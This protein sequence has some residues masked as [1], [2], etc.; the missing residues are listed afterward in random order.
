MII[1]NLPETKYK[2]KDLQ[3]AI[4]TWWRKQNFVI[5]ECTIKKIVIAYN[6][7]NYMLKCEELNNLVEK[8]VKILNY[9][10]N[11]HKYPKGYSEVKLKEI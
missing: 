2:K 5:K 3:Q 8:E 9:Y 1:R 4:E 7:K 11:N 6:I 10:D